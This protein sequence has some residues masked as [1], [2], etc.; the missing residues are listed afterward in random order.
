MSGHAIRTGTLLPN[1]NNAYKED[2]Y[3]LLLDIDEKSEKKVNYM[4]HNGV[5]KWTQ[6][7]S[8]RNL[9]ILDFDTPIQTTANN[10][11]HYFLE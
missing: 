11:Y 5:R 4:S 3:L 7:L 6:L 9:D 10:G 8:E 1:T 2:R